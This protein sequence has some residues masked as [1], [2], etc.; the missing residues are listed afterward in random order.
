MGLCPKGSKGSSSSS[1]S[2]G[3]NDRRRELG[4]PDRGSSALSGVNGAAIAS[5]E[6]GREG[7][8]AHMSGDGVSARREASDPG[9]D[10]AAE[11]G[12][13]MGLNSW[14]L[15]FRIRGEDKGEAGRL[16]VN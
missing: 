13:G 14:A 3:R 12:R 5:F 11:S 9:F 2:P 16:A 6:V 15:A 4:V 8:W 7:L 10:E 1:S